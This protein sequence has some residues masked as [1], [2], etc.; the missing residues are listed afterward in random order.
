MT[1]KKEQGEAR[2]VFSFRLKPETVER[3]RELSK[4]NLSR[5]IEMLLRQYN[6][7]SRARSREYL[8]KKEKIEKRLKVAQRNWF[9]GE[10]RRARQNGD[11]EAI[12]H[13]EGLLSDK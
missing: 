12:K 11:Q 5:T 9:E 3:A 13:Y 6:K 2:P 1:P 4:G 8:T 10:L 7:E